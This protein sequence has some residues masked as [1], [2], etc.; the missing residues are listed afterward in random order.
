MHWENSDSYSFKVSP[1]QEYKRFYD[2]LQD[3]LLLGDWAIGQEQFN[4]KYSQKI[5]ELLEFALFR[6][7]LCRYLY[8][9][10]KE[11]ST[12]LQKEVNSYTKV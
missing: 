7:N 9:N 5:K 4:Q 8:N 10:L 6:T 12:R 2:M 11:I 3:D 1:K